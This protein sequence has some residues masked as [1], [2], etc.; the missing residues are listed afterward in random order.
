MSSLVGQY[1]FMK[2]DGNV[3]L[4]FNDLNNC[5]LCGIILYELEGFSFLSFFFSLSLTLVQKREVLLNNLR[6]LS[7]SISEFNFSWMNWWF[8]EA[9]YR[10]QLTLRLAKPI[11]LVFAS[12]CQIIIVFIVL[13]HG[14]IRHHYI[15]FPFYIITKSMFYSLIKIH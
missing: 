12:N 14:L 6:S 7:Q 9:V 1:H 2:L 15:I 8:K 5:L 13:K 4:T 10:F 11:K 3:F